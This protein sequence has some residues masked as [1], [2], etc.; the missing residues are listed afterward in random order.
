[1]VLKCDLRI[2]SEDTEL[3]LP[4]VKLGVMVYGGGTQR[5]TRLVGL[6]KAL[7]IVLTG[8]RISAQE[9]Y[10]FGL[11]NQLVPRGGLMD[12]AEKMAKSLSEKA[13]DLLR[14]C[15]EAIYRGYDLPIEAALKMEKEIAAIANSKKRY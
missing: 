10:D 13:P 2:A 6:G 14:L 3:G 11:V 9:A 15:K 12:S 1:M 4:E 5:L 8:E 7:Q